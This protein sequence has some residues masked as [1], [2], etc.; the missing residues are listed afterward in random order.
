MKTVTNLLHP[1]FKNFQEIYKY[2]IYLLK[3]ARPEGFEPP[4]SWFVARHSIQLSYGRIVYLK[5]AERE[6][7]FDAA[8]LTLRAAVALLRR[9]PALR[10]GCRTRIL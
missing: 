3:M 8:R 5:L 4:T 10:A 6:G 1:F 9:S 2:L 7:L